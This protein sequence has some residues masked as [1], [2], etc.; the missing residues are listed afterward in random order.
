MPPVAAYALGLGLVTL[1]FLARAWLAPTLG[2]Q[3]LYLFLVPPVLIAGIVGG[4]GPG[5][6]ATAYATVLQ[7]FASG[8]YRALLDIQSPL[9][10]A[11]TA[12]GVTFVVVGV[13][14]AWFGNHLKRA[15]LEAAVVEERLARAAHVVDRVSGDVVRRGTARREHERGQ[16]HEN[17]SNAVNFYERRSR[18]FGVVLTQSS[19]LV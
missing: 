5:V 16:R 7:I 13:G 8:D 10:A 4:L 14:V 3:S 1:V 2:N 18:G 17:S 15:R 12:R 6:T 19:S 11:D 9:F